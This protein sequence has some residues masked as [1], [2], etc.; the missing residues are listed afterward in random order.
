MCNSP[1]ES[2]LLSTQVSTAI[3]PQS[4]S[5]RALTMRSRRIISFLYSYSPWGPTV[6][7][8]SSLLNLPLCLILDIFDELNWPEKVVFSQTCRGLWYPLHYKCVSIF[9]NLTAEN[10]LRY[11]TMLGNVPLDHYTCENCCSLHLINPKDYPSSWIRPLVDSKVFHH[12]CPLPE[13]REGH[14][15]GLHDYAI[16]FR[17]LQLACKYSRLGGTAIHRRYM[18]NILQGWTEKANPEP[19]QSA[20]PGY[21][22]PR[23]NVQPRIVRG[24]FIVRTEHHYFESLP[25]LS[26]LAVLEATTTFCP[27]H[28]LFKK[29]QYHDDKEILEILQSMF[30]QPSGAPYPGFQE[31]S[32]SCSKCPSDYDLV[33]EDRKLTIS[34]WQDLGTGIS[35]EDPFWQSHTATLV[36]RRRWG[37]ALYKYGS[38]KAMFNSA[39][40]LEDKN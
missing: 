3:R 9:Q 11:L 27:H 26:L 13:T 2:H 1:P 21:Q 29:Y 34:V 8:D 39:N 31:R 18:K 22:R 5:D 10:R 36:N 28:I 19:W 16:G 40:T 4:S 24:R 15:S 35:L 33:I 25:E 23:C 6:R 14:I 17:H 32:Y 12:P 37:Q 20:R 7:Q 30:H 38:I